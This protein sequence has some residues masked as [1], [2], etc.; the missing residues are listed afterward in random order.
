MLILCTEWFSYYEILSAYKKLPKGILNI[1]HIFWMKNRSVFRVYYPSTPKS[2]GVTNLDIANEANRNSLVS[3][4]LP[5]A[6]ILQSPTV[7]FQ[8]HIH[9]R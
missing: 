1:K 8:V 4:F 9:Y 6:A 2:Q 7:Y 5:N 3:H